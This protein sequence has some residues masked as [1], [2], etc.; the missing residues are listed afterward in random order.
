MTS[1]QIAFA[2]VKEDRRH[3]RVSESND[4]IKARA[5][6]SQAGASWY[7]ANELQRHNIATESINWYTAQSLAGLQSAQAGKLESE[8]GELVRHNLASE[9]LTQ[10][11]VDI[12]EYDAETRR[13]AQKSGSFK[14][15]T[16][17][18]SAVANAFAN[19]WQTPS[20]ITRNKTQAWSNVAGALGDAV[21]GGLGIM[22]IIK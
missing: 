2:K 15:Y 21:K 16:T 8:T 17:G 3:N 5:A 4:L 14:D 9:D 13:R 18:G 12:S 22:S 20:T 19:L 7:S 1:N 10:Q 6:A 11:Q